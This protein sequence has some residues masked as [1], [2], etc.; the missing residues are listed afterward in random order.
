MK[1]LEEE[2][3]NRELT[4]AVVSVK[5]NSSSRIPSLPEVEARFSDKNVLLRIHYYCNKNNGGGPFTVKTLS[6][7]EKLHLTIISTSVVPFANTSLFFTIIAQV[8]IYIYSKYINTYA[9]IHIYKQA[10]KTDNLL[11]DQ[12]FGFSHQCLEEHASGDENRR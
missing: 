1:E 6:E 9:Y 12:V 2:E 7:I 8:Y 4:E 10:L 3:K 5:N 11:V